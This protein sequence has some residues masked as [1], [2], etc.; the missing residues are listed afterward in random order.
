M[1]ELIILNYLK[2]TLDIPVYMEMPNKLNGEFVLIEKTGSGEENKIKR[3]T[4]AI[5]S[6]STSLYKAAQLNVEVIKAMIG[7]EINT[8]GIIEHEDISKCSLN[9]DY[10]F[11]DLT[12]KKHRYQAVFDLV[13]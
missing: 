6:Y 11:P 7:D 8:Y 5:Q 9:S 12:N 1:I 13:Y 3:A 10:N 4:F 2:S